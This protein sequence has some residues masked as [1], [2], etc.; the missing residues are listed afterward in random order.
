MPDMFRKAQYFKVE[1]PD[2][3]GEF[4]R[5]LQVLREAGVDL[6]AFKGFPRQRRDQLDFVPSDPTAFKSAARRAKWTIKGPKI[7][8]LVEGDDRPGATADILARLAETKINVTATDAVTA[9]AGRF[10]AI[11]WVKP[12]DVKRAARALGIG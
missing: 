1:T 11:L 8:F 9:G 7:C 4:A 3:P 5:S 2:K 12:R 6:L 10:G